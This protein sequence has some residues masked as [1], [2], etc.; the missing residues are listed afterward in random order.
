MKHTKTPWEVEGGSVWAKKSIDPSK[1]GKEEKIRIL[2]GDRRKAFFAPLLPEEMEANIARAVECVNAL[3]GVGDPS[4]AAS[5]LGLVALHL[6][7]GR[8]IEPG[9]LVAK[10]V[11]EGVVGTK[12]VQPCA[13]CDDFVHEGEPC[14]NELCP[15]NSGARRKS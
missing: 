7:E 11:K 12:E 5:A 2:A 3:E 6:S 4:K 15:T 1:R 9:S 13:F 10:A 8:A 14:E